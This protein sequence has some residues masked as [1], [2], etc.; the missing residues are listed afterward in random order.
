MEN[1]YAGFGETW[2][3]LAL[4]RARGICG[5][6]E[7]AY[8]FLQDHQ[9]FIYPKSPTPDLLEEISAIKRRIERDIVGHENLE[10][11]VKLG[12]GGIREIEFIVQ[13]LQLVHGARN[14]FLQ[15]KHAQGP[16][17]SGAARSLAAR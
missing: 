4:I 6:E 16:V 17:R 5:S 10:R 13:A 12:V 2:E 15:E 11:N 3:R 8:E 1:Y 9:P 7:L 14:A